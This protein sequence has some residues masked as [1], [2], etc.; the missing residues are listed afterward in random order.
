MN[1]WY[2]TPAE[3]LQGMNQF[4]S[5]TTSRMRGRMDSVGDSLGAGETRI[6]GARRAAQTPQT[7]AAHTPPAN[8]TVGGG[9]A[10][11]CSTGFTFPG[12]GNVEDTNSP[13]FSSAFTQNFNIPANALDDT[14]R[15]VATVSH[16]GASATAV[17]TTKITCEG[18]EYTQNQVIQPNT[19]NEQIT[20][21]SQ[22]VAGAKTANTPIE[23]E[24]SRVAGSGNDTSQYN[25]VSIINIGIKQSMTSVQTTSPTSQLP[26]SG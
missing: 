16:L 14:L 6:L 5:G 25:S 17:L 15:I 2:N 3:N 1:S 9:N 10:T 11:N 12:V 21:F 4:N 24:I 8:V 20:L 19:A 13:Y 23:V 18:V 26:P 22:R 7:V